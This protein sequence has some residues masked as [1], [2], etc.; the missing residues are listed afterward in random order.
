ME[1]SEAGLDGTWSHL[2]K[3]KVSL[4]MSGVEQDGLDSSFQPNPSQSVVP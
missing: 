2:F 3:L 1:V 4:P